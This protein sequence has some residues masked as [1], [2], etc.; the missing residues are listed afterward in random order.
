MAGPSS[1]CSRPRLLTR[2]YGSYRLNRENCSHAA[3]RE[4][5][6]SRPISS[7]G[8]PAPR[9]RNTAFT[10]AAVA[11]ATWSWVLVRLLSAASCVAVSSYAAV[12]L[13]MLSRIPDEA[14]SCQGTLT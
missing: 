13:L 14:R 3:W 6:I 4:M 12:G 10:R 5:F 11:S 1:R 2:A 7:H 9:H 8:S